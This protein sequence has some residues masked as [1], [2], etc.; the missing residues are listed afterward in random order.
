MQ[1]RKTPNT[2]TFHAV[3]ET[4]ILLTFIKERIVIAVKTYWSIILFFESEKTM[5]VFGENILISNGKS[6]LIPFGRVGKNQ[7]N[8]LFK[9]DHFCQKP[10]SQNKKKSMISYKVFMQIKLID[11]Q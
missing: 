8:I 2:D 11:M 10:D 1:T 5:Q 4:E 7:P 3:L 6:Y 9:V